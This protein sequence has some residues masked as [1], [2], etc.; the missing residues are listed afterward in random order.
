METGK[1]ARTDDLTHIARLAQSPETHHLFQALRII[2]AHSADS[3]RLG[4]S[5][6]P[7]QD[8]VRLGQEAELSFPTSTIAKF[9][10]SHDGAPAQLS[11]RAFGMFGPQGPL[12]LHLTEYA[13]DRQRN[14]RDNTFVA[15]ANMLTH[16]LMTLFYRAWRTGQP[17]PSFDRPDTDQFER[18]VA[19][20]SGYDGNAFRTRDDMPDLAKRYFA[21]HL[22]AGNKTAEG[23]VSMVSAF[24]EA[25]VR[26]KEF[27]GTWLDLEPEDRWQLGTPARLGKT[28]SI[29]TRV[30]TRGSKFRIVVGPLG[31]KDYKRFLPG[32][33]SLE[34][35][36][37]I[38]RNHVGDAFDWD[39]NVIL[40]AAEVPRSAI[41]TTAALGHTTWLG[42]RRNTGKD[43]DDLCLSPP[44]LLRRNV[45]THQANA[46]NVSTKTA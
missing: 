8:P 2:E 29:G 24:F 41:G 38:V 16:R 25:P 42:T 17:A 13:R 22:A 40:K 9:V 10:P 45:V 35:L 33:G 46:L 27:I 20:L 31:L 43:A 21:G 37:A 4:T 1:R 19:A 28:T 32:Q 39:V 23:L 7:Q 36:E 34:Q 26:M 30:W 12:P 11:N 14:H 15:F 6:R 18:K 44:S 3:P 5:R